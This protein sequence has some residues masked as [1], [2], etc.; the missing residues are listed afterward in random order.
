VG[1]WT[2]YRD[3]TFAYND[4]QVPASDSGKITAIA[5]YLNANPSLQ[6]GIDGSM[7]PHGTD[8]KDQALDDRRVEAVRTALIAAG[9]PAWRI[10]TGAFGTA[11]SHQDRHVEV[12]FATAN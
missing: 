11:Q 1:Q 10:K 5:A 2:F 6:L 9:V 3:V 7:D 12:L 8:P 4:A